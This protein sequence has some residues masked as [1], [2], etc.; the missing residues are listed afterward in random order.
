MKTLDLSGNNQI[1]KNGIKA[2][3]GLKNIFPSLNIIGIKL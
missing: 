3:K 2:L 1:G